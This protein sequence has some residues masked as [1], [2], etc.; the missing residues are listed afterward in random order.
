MNMMIMIMIMIT[1]YKSHNTPSN[2][3]T[4]RSNKLIL[5]GSILTINIPN[6]AGNGGIIINVSHRGTRNITCLHAMLMGL[7]SPDLL[8]GIEQCN[9]KK[10]KCFL[11]LLYKKTTHL[12]IHCTLIKF[13]TKMEICVKTFFF[14]YYHESGCVLGD[15][16]CE[17]NVWSRESCGCL[18]EMMI[19]GR[20]FR[21][22]FS[23]SHFM[24]SSLLILFI[25]YFLSL[26]FFSKI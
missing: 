25:I 22:S 18:Q 3:N 1:N 26:D 23:L 6:T 21:R 11:W 20:V 10:P 5:S 12:C 2:S 4:P 16:D 19:R 8:V 13:T 7:W 9:L 24:F 15:H 17:T 14:C